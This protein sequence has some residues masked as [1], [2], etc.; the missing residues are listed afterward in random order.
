MP[1]HVFLQYCSIV[2][3]ASICLA[4]GIIDQKTMKIPNPF[5]ISVATLG[6]IFWGTQ[7][8]RDLWLQVA[9]A[10]LIL[11]MMELFRASFRKLRGKEGLGMGDVKLIAAS[12]VWITPAHISIFLL[13]ASATALLKVQ[14]IPPPKITPKNSTRIPFGPYLA[15]SLLC[16]VCLQY[17][18]VLN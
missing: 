1:N 17:N 3:L 15:A 7:S 12:A 4:I 11:L 8:I 14:C 9:F 18:G 2:A 10:I 6:F 13:L 16:T 5:T